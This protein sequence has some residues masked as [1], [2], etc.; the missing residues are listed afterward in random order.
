MG[1][2]LYLRVS[3]DFSKGSIAALKRFCKGCRGFLQCRV[4]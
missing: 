4:S 2:M 1:V 3:W